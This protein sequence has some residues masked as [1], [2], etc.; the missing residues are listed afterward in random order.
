MKKQIVTLTAVAALTAGAA[1][2]A[3]ASSTHTVEKGDTLWSIS[4][5]NNVTV[6]ELNDWNNLT[7]TIIY[8]DQE[9]KVSGDVEKKTYSVVSGDT[10]Y[11][12]AK[13]NNIPLSTLMSWN[14]LSSGLIFP[15]DQLVVAG[16]S[17]QAEAP[18]E[19]VE[20]A[21]VEEV[22]VEEAP[23]EEAPAE[24]EEGVA[25]TGG[26]NAPSSDAVQ[27]LTVTATA[28]T[29]FCEGCSGTTA[30]GIDLRANPDQKVIAVDPDVIP[31]GS[32]V[33][34]E[35]YGEA[36]AGDTGGAITGNKIDLFIP[37]QEEAIE[38]GVQEV[39]VKVL[40]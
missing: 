38:Y 21:P 16:G 30:T 9:L 40:N 24:S 27:E 20:E 31:L 18:A 8:P 11:K 25:G 36:I 34:V 26:D 19:P 17:E 23:A 33:W 6:H 32:K 29:A 14:G 15:G 28:Y 3:S 39:T 12:I 37:S 35:G 5:A 10:L 2:S 22:P 13:E 4:Q 1:S 7:S